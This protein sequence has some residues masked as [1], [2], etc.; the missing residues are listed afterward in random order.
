MSSSSSEPTEEFE[1]EDSGD[2]EEVEDKGSVAD[3]LTEFFFAAGDFLFFFFFPPLPFPL[4]DSVNS[5]LEE[6]E[7]EA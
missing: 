5:S 4:E 6:E 2:S 7:E 3:L 1:L